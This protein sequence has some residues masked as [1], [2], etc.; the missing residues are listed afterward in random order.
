MPS[1]HGLS[2]PSEK[3][4]NSKRRLSLAGASNAFPVQGF[5]DFLLYF[6][7]TSV[8]VFYCLFF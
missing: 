3:R 6:I 8:F 1:K 4:V 5:L 2:T 7:Q